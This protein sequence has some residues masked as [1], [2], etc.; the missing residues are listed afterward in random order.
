MY[1]K[2]KGFI[3][4]Y[5]LA[6]FL[7]YSQYLIN[8]LTLKQKEFII[9]ENLKKDYSFYQE[10]RKILREV[11]CDLKNGKIK[12]EQVIRNIIYPERRSL[13]IKLDLEKKEVVEYRFQVDKSS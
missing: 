8:E 6:L 1:H 10:E 13:K 9:Q 12:E 11:E 4:I 7:F 5:F 2:K 3:S